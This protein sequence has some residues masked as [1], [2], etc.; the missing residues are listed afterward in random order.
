MLGVERPLPQSGYY[1][2]VSTRVLSQLSRATAAV[3]SSP[4]IR[5]FGG[6][7]SNVLQPLQTNKFERDSRLLAA[8][9]CRLEWTR[10]KRMILG[11]RI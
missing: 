7:V 11:T 8:N 6:L 1:R 5:F 9:T 2:F 3:L 4:A 10:A